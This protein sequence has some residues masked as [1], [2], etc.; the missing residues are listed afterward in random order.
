MPLAG[1]GEDF[2]H[3]LLAQ[4]SELSFFNLR[5]V[6]GKTASQCSIQLLFNNKFLL[7]LDTNFGGRGER[8]RGKKRRE[9]KKIV[10]DDHL[11]GVRFLIVKPFLR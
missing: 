7:L 1:L 5:M 4:R 6:S 10:Y 9:E 3:S 11:S 2:F 8:E